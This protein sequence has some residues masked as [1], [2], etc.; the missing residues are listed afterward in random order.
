MNEPRW[1]QILC[2]GAVT[3]FFGLPLGVFIL[4]FAAI[5]FGW[6]FDN[7]IEEFA[8]IM[9]VYQTITGL[10]FGLAG[11]NS[12]DKYNGRKRKN[13]PVEKVPGMPEAGE[14]ERPL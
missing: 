11:L 12:W 5:E 13:E 6:Q 9:P 3:M 7:R 8:G 14:R 4:H 2:W 1:R 10:V